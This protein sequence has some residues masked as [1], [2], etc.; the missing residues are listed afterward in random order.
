MINALAAFGLGYLFFK[1][2]QESNGSE[3]VDDSGSEDTQDE[4]STPST[5]YDTGKDQF[6]VESVYEKDG[7]VLYCLYSLEGM[8]Y[9]K[10]DGTIDDGTQYVKTGFIVGDVSQT[11]FVSQNLDRGSRDITLNGIQHDNVSIFGSEAEGKAYIDDKTTPDDDG[12]QTLPENDPPAPPP[13]PLPPTT[14]PG[15]GD[16]SF[17]TFRG[18]GGAY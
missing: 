5:P 17:G 8:A 7:M 10:A 4:A 18:M 15:M 3:G 1:F 6:K 12:P 16:T 2:V 9:E 13:S 11:S 14:L